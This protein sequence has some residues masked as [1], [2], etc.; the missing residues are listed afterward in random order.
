[1][2]TPLF[3]EKLRKGGFVIK[4]AGKYKI[5]AHFLQTHQTISINC[6]ICIDKILKNIEFRIIVNV[7]FFAI[8]ICYGERSYEI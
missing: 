2:R 3:G 1:M 8:E 7:K 4:M 5:I 6:L